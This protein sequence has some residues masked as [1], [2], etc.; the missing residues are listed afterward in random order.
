MFTRPLFF[1]LGLST[2][3]EVRPL[4]I[5]TLFCVESINPN[6]GVKP[7]RRRKRKDETFGRAQ[8]SSSSETTRRTSWRTHLTKVPIR[9]LAATASA[10]TRTRSL[11]PASPSWSAPRL[12][13]YKTNHYPT[14]LASYAPPH[15]PLLSPRVPPKPPSFI[16]VCRP[17]IPNPFPSIHTPPIPLFAFSLS[18]PHA[19]RTLSLLFHQLLAP[20]P[21]PCMTIY[22]KSH[23]G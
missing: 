19:C 16:H 2:L 5:S 17:L 21:L 3:F 1:N 7:R 14:P 15:Q 20:K 13:E 18:F 8:C 12:Q 4:F 10:S 6:C 22:R 11:T 23:L 9:T